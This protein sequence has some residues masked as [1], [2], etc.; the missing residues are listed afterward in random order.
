MFPVGRA[1]LLPM[2][3]SEDFVCAENCAAEQVKPD[4]CHTPAVFS[5]FDRL[6]CMGHCPVLRST[7]AIT[8]AA[9]TSRMSGVT[10][11]HSRLSDH[12][13]FIDSAACVLS[14]DHSTPLQLWHCEQDERSNP[15]PQQV[16]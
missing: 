8:T 15:R 13:H 12:L 11:D 9:A 16:E 1:V 10:R 5:I 7:I 6:R 14:F 3:V 4:C 2:R